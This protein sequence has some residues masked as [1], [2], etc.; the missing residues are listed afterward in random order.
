[1]TVPNGRRQHADDR[2]NLCPAQPA[3]SR[4][5]KTPRRRQDHHPRQARHLVL[6]RPHAARLD[7]LSAAL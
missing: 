1:V 2:S 3:I 5:L 7:A 4:H 6:P